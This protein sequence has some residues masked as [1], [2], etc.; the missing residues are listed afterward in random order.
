MSASNKAIIARLRTIGSPALSFIGGEV[1]DF[2]QD[3]QQ[4]TMSFEATPTMCH[5]KVIVQGGFIT[6]MVDSAMAYACMGCF[7]DRIAVPTLEIKVSFLKAGNA[8]TMI[9]KA[10]ALHLGKS[11]GFLEAELYQHD[12]LIATSS[13]TVRLIDLRAKSRASSLPQ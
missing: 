7:E 11:V 5:S 6:A 13:S 3:K 1:I 12:H 9:A 4:I 2:D 10:R 8:G